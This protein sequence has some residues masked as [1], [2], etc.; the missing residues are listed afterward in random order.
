[1]P[2]WEPDMQEIIVAVIVVIAAWSVLS[3]YAPK[4]LRQACRAQAAKLAR[5]GGFAWL[6]KRLTSPAAPAGSCA[7]GCGNC[8]GCSPAATQPETRS[9]ITPEALKRT[10]RR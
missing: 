7:D 5:R 6:E 2:Y 9:A 10:I 1:V 3:R 8:G 4:A